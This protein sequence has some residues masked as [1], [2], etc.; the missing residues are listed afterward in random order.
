MEGIL[1]NI[2]ED[3]RTFEGLF[4]HTTKTKDERFLFQ[5]MQYVEW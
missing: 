5:D 4:I 1:I 2:K 3:E